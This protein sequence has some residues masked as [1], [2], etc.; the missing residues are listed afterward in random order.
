[1]SNL[2]ARLLTAALVVPVLLVAIFWSNP[3]GVWVIVIVATGLALRE[4]FTVTMGDDSV[5][6][7]LGVAIGLAYGSALY[8]L[9][10][11]AFESVAML[12]LFSFLA[13]LV[14]VGDTPET[15]RKA[16]ERVGVTAFGVLYC[17]LLAFLALL[18]REQGP[19]GYK[20]ILL[21]LSVT[22]LGDT[23]AYAAGRI[24]GRHKLYSKVSPGKTWEGALGGLAWS[25]GA[26]AV[27]HLWYF[28][29]LSWGHA[30]AVSLP[31]GA[32]GVVGDLCE[33]M[34][35]RAYGVKDSGALLPGHGGILDR[36]DA[37]LFA[38]PYFY[39]FSHWAF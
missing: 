19:N 3:I 15:M 17:G 34:W 13:S 5:A 18:K 9:T 20:W 6:L 35:K 25:F 27:A 26:A 30:A 37:L 29:E 4:W 1:M 14:R 8:W 38:A 23:G 24:A 7:W 12:V 10:R 28:P 31:A 22:W 21:L 16:A 36:I 2:A 11:F 32:L 33:S 39:F